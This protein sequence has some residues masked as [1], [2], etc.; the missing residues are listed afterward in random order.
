MK[1][2]IIKKLFGYFIY[3]KIFDDG[4]KVLVLVEVYLLEV[5]KVFVKFLELKECSLEWL[6]FVVVVV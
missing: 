6:L 3:F 2:K 5:K 1:G 4:C